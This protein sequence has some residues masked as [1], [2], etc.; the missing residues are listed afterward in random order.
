M[1]IYYKF[2]CSFNKLFSFMYLVLPCGARDDK[3]MR[4]WQSVPKSLRTS[5]VSKYQT[6][7]CRK[8]SPVSCFVLPCVS[9]QI[10]SWGF[11]NIHTSLWMALVG[12]LWMMNWKGCGT[13]KSWPILGIIPEFFLQGPRKELLDSLVNFVQRL[14]AKVCRIY[15]YSRTVSFVYYFVAGIRVEIRY[16]EQLNAEQ[17]C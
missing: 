10:R 17:E 13:E 1:N 15:S 3:Q 7:A 8:T 4:I 9:I 6:S 12:W 11:N 2:P 14:L 16:H 5:A